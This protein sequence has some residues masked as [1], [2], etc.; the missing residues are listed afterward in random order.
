MPPSGIA[1]TPIL[2]PTQFPFEAPDLRL[3][4][5]SDLNGYDERG[6]R[7]YLVWRVECPPNAL[8]VVAHLS[9]TGS[10]RRPA[11]VASL[12]ALLVAPHVAF[13]V[14]VLVASLVASELRRDDGKLQ[15]AG[16]ATE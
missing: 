2:A 13:L 16:L 3:S 9:S 14:A 15:L 7:P 11:Q 8:K 1:G 10:G 6:R 12:V 5:G 4:C